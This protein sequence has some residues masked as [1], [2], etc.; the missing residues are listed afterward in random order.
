MPTV[1]SGQE[2]LLTALADVQLACERVCGR[3][4]ETYSHTAALCDH[5]DV[6]LVSDKLLPI[7]LAIRDWSREPSVAERLRRVDNRRL[8]YLR[9]LFATFVTGPDDVEAS[10]TLAFTLVI[11]NHFMATDHGARSR[12]GALELAVKQ[13]MA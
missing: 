9:S 13:L 12:H 2:D 6:R 11:G 8:D 3:A 10:S 1:P 7:D 4:D 5:P